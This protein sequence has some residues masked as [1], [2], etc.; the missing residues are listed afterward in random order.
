MHRMR[1][2]VLLLFSTAAAA[3]D[4][5]DLRFSLHKSG[6][7]GTGPTILIVGGI[8]GDEPGGFNAASLLVTDY[9]ISKGQLWV[10][11]NLNFASIIYRSRGIHGDM[12]RKFA[13]LD[14][15]D[16]EFD[17][18][19][20]IK[21]IITDPQ[22]DL[23]LNL[24]DGSGFYRRE[25]IDRKH[26]PQRWGQ[27]LIIDQ[28]EL[29][30][31]KYGQ[32]QRLAEQVIDSVNSRIGTR[33]HRF[34]VRNTR[35]R[36]GDREM[37]KTLTYFAIRN[38]QPAFG[39][40][41][42]KEFLTAERAYF[43]LH[44]VEAFMQKLG[45]TYQRKFELNAVAVKRRIDT[46]VK[47]ALYRNRLFFDMAHVRARLNH[48]PMQKD[49]PLEFSASN[50]LVAIIDKK[51]HYQVRYGNRRVTRL[52]P[53]YLT[54]DNSLQTVRMEVDGL[55]REVSLG[56][57]VNVAESFRIIPEAGYRTNVIGF[58]RKGL[59]NESDVRITR[60]DIMRRFSVDRQARLYRVEFYRANRF[61]GML[62]VDFSATPKA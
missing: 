34:A 32:L 18:V 46:N 3:Q 19:Q 14:E 57:V 36:D 38:E 15:N 40:E 41:A 45:I 31:V 53:E 30:G 13:R 28:A 7:P 62:L 58:T 8:Q 61:C 23:V 10:V 29:A 21:A 33:K 4:P 2:L 48:V 5:L 50:P 56:S 59:A 6:Q 43:H 37:E 9:R 1:L 51:N 22:V 49:R 54:F 27:S 55:I 52:H 25:Y 17:A 16:P 12:N 42:S 60:K 39:V 26:N 11:P 47:L 44:V 20:T 24:H 35:T